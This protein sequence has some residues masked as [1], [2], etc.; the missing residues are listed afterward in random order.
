M[1]KIYEFNCHVLCPHLFFFSSRRRHTRYWRDWSSDVCSSDLGFDA[2]ARLFS[3]QNSHVDAE[4]E[5][6]R[7]LA[8]K[9]SAEMHFELGLT[10]ERLGNLD[11]AP[12]ECR[13]AIRFNPPLAPSHSLLGVLLRR[14]G[15]HIGAPSQFPQ[16]VAS[17]PHKTASQ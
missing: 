13:R 14:Q 11:V 7:A 15:H 4:R 6:R 1:R 3:Q 12:A 16:A 17:D 9:P 2:S 8:S 5:L 10:E